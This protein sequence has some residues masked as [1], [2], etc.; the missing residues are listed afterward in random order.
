L[1]EIEAWFDDKKFKFSHI[2]KKKKKKKVNS[3]GGGPKEMK[4]TV[5][6]SVE[7]APDFF[8]EFFLKILLHFTQL[9]VQTLSSLAQEV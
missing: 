7:V 9:I 3:G 6:Y 2:A 1:H 8:F 5:L 4:T